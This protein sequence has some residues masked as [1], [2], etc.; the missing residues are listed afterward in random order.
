MRRPFPSPARG[1]AFRSTSACAE[2]PRIGGDCS[3][4]YAGPPPHRRREGSEDCILRALRPVHPRI[5]GDSASKRFPLCHS[6]LTARYR[7]PSVRASVTGVRGRRPSRGHA[8]RGPGRERPA[9]HRGSRRPTGRSPHGCGRPCSG[10][11]S[12]WSKQ[13]LRRLLQ[14][15]TITDTKVFPGGRREAPRLRVRPLLRGLRADQGLTGYRVIMLRSPQAQA[16]SAS[17]HNETTPARR[18]PP[19]VRHRREV[20]FNAHR[21]YQARVRVHHRP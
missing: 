12:E 7:N 3:K 6:P 19:G 5:G 17:A 21:A 2:H 13:S 20:V 4:H 9:S 14:L 16:T 15:S 10:R 11:Y 18:Q 8:C 1:A